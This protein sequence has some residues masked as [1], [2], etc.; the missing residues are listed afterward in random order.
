MNKQELRKYY[1]KVR[2]NIFKYNKY[3]LDKSIL[4][5]ILSLDEYKNADTVFT[6]VSFGSEVDTK[7]LILEAFSDNKKVAV[8][9]CISNTYKIDFYYINNINELEIGSFGILEPNIA[10]A[11][12]V[13]D[14]NNFNDICIIPGL[15]FT[16]NGDRLGYG[17]GYYDRFLEKYG[18]NIYKIG[19]CYECQ[20]CSE[21]PTDKYDKCM[22]IVVSEN[23]IRGIFKNG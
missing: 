13:V 14:F 7:Q 5:N 21:L 12:K 2:N 1:K 18:N 23:H 4:K 10:T 17:K 16:Y 22:D 6:Y 11:K 8:P 20:I 19:I 15:S 9:Y 3:E